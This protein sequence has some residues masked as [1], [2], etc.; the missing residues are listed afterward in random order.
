MAAL[1]RTLVTEHPQDVAATEG[2]GKAERLNVYS[3]HFLSEQV[4]KTHRRAAGLV[5]VVPSHG[6]A[7]VNVF[8]RTL[9]IET[10]L[11]EAEV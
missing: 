6:A 10:Y 9:Y 5:R 8:D 4:V 1:I 2:Q 7:L 11:T 3:P